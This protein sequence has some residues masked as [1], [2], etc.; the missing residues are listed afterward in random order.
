MRTLLLPLL[1]GF[2]S[3]IYADMRS[4]NK[5]LFGNARDDIA[6]FSFERPA[7]SQDDPFFF[8]SCLPPHLNNDW[9][10]VL[11]TILIGRPWAEVFSLYSKKCLTDRVEREK[12]VQSA[13]SYIHDG[14]AHA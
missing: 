1:Q 9:E 4:Y 3:C 7:R 12:G 2:V 11:F 6:L 13:S 14:C 8:Y 10:W 5:I